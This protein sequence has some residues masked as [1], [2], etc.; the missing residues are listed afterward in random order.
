MPCPYITEKEGQ[1]MDILGFKITE[2]HDLKQPYNKFAGQLSKWYNGGEIPVLAS[3]D[4]RLTLELQRQKLRSLGLDMKCGLTTVQSKYGDTGGLTYCDR[5]FSNSIVS[6]NAQLNRSISDKSQGVIF[7][8]KLGITAVIQDLKGETRPSADMAL[9]CPH[10][11]APSTLGELESGCRFCDTQFLMSELFPKVMNIFIGRKKDNS[12]KNKRD[13]AICLAVGIVPML[14]YA[15]ISGSDSLAETIAAGI[16]TGGVI[17]VSLFVFKKMIE[18]FA[19]M[20]KTARGGSQAL[21][22]VHYLSKIKRHDP[23]FSTE[24]FR[25][26]AISLFRMAVYSKNAGELTCCKCQ[27]PKKLADIIEADIYNFGVNSCKIK[28]EVCNADV[29][30]YLDTLHYKNGKIKDRTDKVRMNMRKR[31]KKPTELGFSFR[32][33]SCPSCGASFDAHKAKACPF[34]HAE[35]DIEEND[36]VVTDIR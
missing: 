7:D 33:V 2:N 34:C 10:C 18:T 22:S 24:Y 20:G 9:C 5:I 35:Y 14:I 25:D 4:M 30:L 36:W 23:E 28:D 15:L 12:P 3:Q 6:G 1:H 27:C 26:K 31:I 8:E 19:L 29:T 13:F 32:A 21:S 11:G 17:G 16:I